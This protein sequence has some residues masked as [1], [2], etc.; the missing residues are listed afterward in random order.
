MQQDSQKAYY[1][2]SIVA[3][4]N[5]YTLTATRLA[6]QTADTKC[7]NLTLTHLNV[8]GCTAEGCDVGRCW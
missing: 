6:P 3:T 2:L 7:G 4:S 8:K 5:A 1:R